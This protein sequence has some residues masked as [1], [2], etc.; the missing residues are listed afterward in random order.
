V[1]TTKAAYVRIGRPL[2]SGKDTYVVIDTA[3]LP[4][5]VVER[6][7]DP[8]HCFIKPADVGAMDGWI[9]QRPT[10]SFTA[11]LQAAIIPPKMRKIP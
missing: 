5:L 1:E 10:H 8:G 11:V 9:E 3:N 2:R 4:G 6:A 7:S